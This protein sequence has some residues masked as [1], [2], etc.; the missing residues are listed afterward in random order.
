MFFSD[1]PLDYGR[2]NAPFLDLM[3]RQELNFNRKKP[4]IMKNFIFTSPVLIIALLVLL[5]GC[6]PEHKQQPDPPAIPQPVN[7][8]IDVN[9]LLNAN[10]ATDTTE[11]GKDA[12]VDVTSQEKV[13]STVE[14]IINGVSDEFWAKSLEYN[15]VSKEEAVSARDADPITYAE[16]LI[17]AY[18]SSVKVS[19]SRLSQYTE[20]ELET[21]AER[22]AKPLYDS[23]SKFLSVVNPDYDRNPL[24]EDAA[25]E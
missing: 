19:L 5:T 25:E 20:E 1:L 13:S 2:G 15:R 11:A 10:P 4:Q 8:I 23:F 17:Q 22:T 3:Q 6:A 14:K 7:V 24:S 21:I 18:K 16:D 12:S 9:S